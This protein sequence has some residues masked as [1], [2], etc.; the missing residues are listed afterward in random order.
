MRYWK[1][2]SRLSKK[3]KKMRVS[4]KGLKI[5]IFTEK[6]GTYLKSS[7]AYSREHADWYKCAFEMNIFWFPFLNLD[8]WVVKSPA[9][10]DNISN[11]SFLSN[12]CQVMAFKKLSDY[13]CINSLVWEKTIPLW[14]QGKSW[15]WHLGRSI[16]ALHCDNISFHW[17]E[18]A[19]LCVL[20]AETP[21]SSFQ[22]EESFGL[23]I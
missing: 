4:G 13:I 22:E 2:W 8:S 18:H 12:A 7:K 15:P 14:D 21:A 16:N 17:Q 1:K 9:F 6:P 23:V 19:W 3:K 5:L 20:D 11:E 10:N